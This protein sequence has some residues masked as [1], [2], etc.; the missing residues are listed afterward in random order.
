MLLAFYLISVPLSDQLCVIR[1]LHSS[2]GLVPL[3]CFCVALAPLDVIRVSDGV[4]ASLVFSIS[5]T[6]ICINI[7]LFKDEE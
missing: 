7:S 4:L 6:D 2:E 1:F 5:L 3:T